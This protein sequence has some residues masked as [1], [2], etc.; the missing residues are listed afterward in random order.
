MG[1]R[2]GAAVL[3]ATIAFFA[4][5]SAAIADGPVGTD[6]GS[7]FVVGA[8]P[9]AC[10]TDPTG[11]ACIE[12][13]VSYLDQA[14]ASL[15][16]PPYALPGDFVSLSP[17]QQS[18]ILANL[19]RTLYGLAPVQGLT[20]ALEQDAAIGVQDDADPQPSSPDW[21]GFTS[22]WAGGYDNIVLAYEAWM[23]DDGPG[24]GNLDCS[25]PGSSGCWA[26]R[27]D[28]LW[29]F[30]S[31]GGPLAM[32]AAAGADS[33]GNP[34]YAMLIEQKTPESTPSFVYTWAQAVADGA[35]GASAQ[36]TGSPQGGSPSPASSGSG[37]PAGAHIA[38][39]GIRLERVRSRGHRVS[40][41][42]LAPRRLLLRCSL[43]GQ[44]SGG[45]K[46]RRN[47]RCGRRAAFMHLPA[48]RYWLR[49]TSRVGSVAR[50]VTLS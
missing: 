45:G 33:G 36:A 16:Q 31:G 22:N 47:K 28:V 43:S 17:A 13:A 38:N 34:G 26:H 1:I 39:A 23:Y 49:V 11:A 32:G 19:D 42:I 41:T 35:G 46:V 4:S 37:S 8:L 25:S 29:Q 9:S 40:F 14:R 3:G 48:G 15:G 21:L 5:G 44:A 12:A 6:P 30:D 18:F 2:L 24:S 50:L 10:Q 27:H 7:N 20:A